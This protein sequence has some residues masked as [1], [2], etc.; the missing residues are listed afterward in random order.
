MVV[1]GGLMLLIIPGHE[2][3]WVPKG[4]LSV[5]LSQEK[6][7]LRIH[8]WPAVHLVTFENNEL[9]HSELSQT[10]RLMGTA[11]GKIGGLALKI[12]PGDTTNQELAVK[13]V[14]EAFSRYEPGRIFWAEFRL[15]FSSVRNKDQQAS[16]KFPIWMDMENWTLGTK[17]HV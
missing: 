6:A 17:R 15:P 11:Q 13:T 1:L 3:F 9:Y 12:P 2:N 10:G 7:N 5:G 4:G 8:G 14:D 16:A